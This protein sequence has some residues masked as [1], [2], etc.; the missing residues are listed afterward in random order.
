MERRSIQRAS[1]GWRAA[2]SHG[3]LATAMAIK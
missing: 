1:P 2:P 3:D